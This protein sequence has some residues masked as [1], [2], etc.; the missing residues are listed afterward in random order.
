MNLKNILGLD[1][2]IKPLLNK[3]NEHLTQQAQIIALLEEIKILQEKKHE[4]KN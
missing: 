4:S 2:D 3:I 1:L